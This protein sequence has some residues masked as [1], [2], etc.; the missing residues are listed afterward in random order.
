MSLCLKTYLNSDCWEASK[1]DHE[2]DE[3]SCSVGRDLNEDGE[4]IDL[5]R[6]TGSSVSIALKQ[7]GVLGLLLL[8]LLRSS[9]SKIMLV[10]FRLGDHSIGDQS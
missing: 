5:D 8:V 2:A 1:S 6:N 4:R 3:D 7:L 9:F 10:E